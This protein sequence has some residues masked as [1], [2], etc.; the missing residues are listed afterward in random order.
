MIDQYRGWVTMA[1]AASRL[2]QLPRWAHLFSMLSIAG[3]PVPTS[4]QTAVRIAAGAAVV[5]LAAAA[6]RRHAP[7]WAAVLIFS[8]SGCFLMLFSPRTENNT[9]AALAP[10]VGAFFA[11]AWR[12]DR[13]LLAATFVVIALGMLGSYE[14]GHLLTPSASPTWLAPLVTTGFTAFVVAGVFAPSAALV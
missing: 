4:V 9:Y 6:R 5:W 10:A 2:G 8:L 14:V 12:D 11:A 1:G 13:R 7:P 3:L